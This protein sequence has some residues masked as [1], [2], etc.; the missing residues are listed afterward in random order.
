MSNDLPEHVEQT[1]NGLRDL[2][3]WASVYSGKN[4]PK[5]MQALRNAIALLSQ[6]RLCAREAVL[7]VVL[8][9]ASGDEFSGDPELDV[10]RERLEKM[11]YE[12]VTGADDV[13]VP[14]YAEARVAK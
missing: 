14:L 13:R 12:L 11:Q 2:D 1:L 3:R 8:P 7:K 4:M 10:R 6:Y 5:R 9:G